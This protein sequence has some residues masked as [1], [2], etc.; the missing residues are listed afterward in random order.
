MNYRL[1]WSSL[2]WVAAE[3]LRQGYRNKEY[4]LNPLSTA[5]LLE[6]WSTTTGWYRPEVNQAQM[7]L[8]DSHDVPRALHSLSGDIKALKLALLLLF[9]HPGAPC[10]YYGTERGLAGGPD[11]ELLGGPRTGMPRSIPLGEAMGHRSECVHR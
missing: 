4:P 7:N 10:L 2:C 3:G 6:M 11:A 8:L 5:R 1:G 9:L